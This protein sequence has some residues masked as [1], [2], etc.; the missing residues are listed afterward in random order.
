M[1]TADFLFP[2]DLQVS[3]TNFEKILIIGSCLSEV[4]TIRLRKK[5]PGTLIDYILFN[6][7][8]ELPPKA[9]EEL[10]G[11]NLQYIQLPLR[12]VLTDGVVR[13]EDGDSGASPVD[14]LEIGRQNIARMLEKAMAYASQASML[15]FVANFIVP[16]GRIAA[17]LDDYESDRDLVRVIREL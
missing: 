4:Y 17:S 9:V 8:S 12:S 3:P 7:A 14:W 5:W 16:Q 15:T 10:E 2:R 13:I 11:Y 1:N 6:N